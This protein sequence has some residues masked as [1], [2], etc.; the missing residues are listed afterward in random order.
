MY[1]IYIPWHVKN[2]KGP[3][4]SMLKA[5]HHMG[6]A[7]RDV[8]DDGSRETTTVVTDGL[9]KRVLERMITQTGNISKECTQIP[10]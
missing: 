4:S 1:S 10:S 2:P 9:P 8:R 7:Q 3:S 5:D 6:S